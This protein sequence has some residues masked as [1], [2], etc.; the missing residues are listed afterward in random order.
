MKKLIYGTLFLALVGIGVSSCK[1]EKLLDSLSN[2]QSSS[3]TKVDNPT[4]L[5]KK[6]KNPFAIEN[7]RNAYQSLTKKKSGG[8]LQPNRLYVRFLPLTVEEMVSIDKDS[9][10]FEN[11]PI[12]VEVNNYGEYYLDPETAHL[13]TTWQYTT[14]PMDYRFNNVRY[15]ILD[16][17]F[18]TDEVEDN[19]RSSIGVDLLLLEAKA[20]ELA[21]YVEEAEA[22][23]QKAQKTPKGYVRFQQKIGSTVTNQPVKSMRV[24]S[25]WWFRY[26]KAYTNDNGFFQCD[27]DYKHTRNV[28]VKVF[29]ENQ[30]VKIRGIQGG[31]ILAMFNVED[32][33]LGTFSNNN[34]E[35]INYIFTNTPTLQSSTKR[36]WI[37]C[38]GLN[39]VLEYRNYCIS[40]GVTTPPGNLNM[41]ISGERREDGFTWVKWAAAPMLK[42]MSNSSM[43]TNVAKF[44]ISAKSPLFAA[45]IQVFQIFA[46]DITYNYSSNTDY[47][48]NSDR[49]TQIFYHELAHAS[50]YAKVGNNYW[51][52]YIAYIIANL[53]YGT[54]DS[55][56]A[57]LVAISE[58]WAEFCGTRFTHLKFGN[59]NSNPENNNSWLEYIE[60][61]KPYPNPD[62]WSY[63]NWIP[64]GIMHD[65][66]DIGE[67]V[68]S[69]NPNVIDNVS[70]FTISQCFGSMDPD[71]TTVNGYKNRFILEYGIT[72]QTSINTLFTT[73]GY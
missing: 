3:Q 71:I 27:K 25:R 66:T 59:N 18:L 8:E 63:W 52:V 29:F 72:Q 9:L 51:T 62:N 35:N 50:H 30:Y 4:V 24:Q 5:G 49:I 46:P 23:I 61:F 64:D 55:Y 41:W 14:V 65:L 42:Q 19:Y 21:G 32:N 45:L 60:R 36:K 47:Y 53:G 2:K 68:W 22:S 38:H 33:T 34:L 70:G 54:S 13:G 11:I 26:G 48:T 16:S 6:L 40:N 12:D 20:L 1:K 7:M 43:I 28:V 31:G 10:I 17:L 58:A 56:G 44:V 37:A 57:G 15:E 67:P 69:D 39:S 73:Y